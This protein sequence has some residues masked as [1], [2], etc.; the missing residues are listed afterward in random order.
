MEKPSVFTTLR[1]SLGFPVAQWSRICRFDLRV[2][3]I[4]LEK[5]MATHYS[6]F[7]W[8]ISQTGESGGPQSMAGLQKSWT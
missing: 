7:S 8:E 3:K 1:K 2:E 6:I 5:E 4:P